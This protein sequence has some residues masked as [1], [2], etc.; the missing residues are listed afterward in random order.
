MDNRKNQQFSS[1]TSSD[2]EL[3]EELRKAGLEVTRKK[4]SNNRI[5]KKS[6]NNTRCGKN[7]KIWLM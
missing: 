4:N 1:E 3:I 7:F 5:I 6:D 2:E